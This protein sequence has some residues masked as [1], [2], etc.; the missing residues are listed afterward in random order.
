MDEKYK[1]N[2]LRAGSCAREVRAYG[3]SL[4][5]KGASYNDIIAKIYTKIQEVGA[6]PAFPPQM[7]LNCT[8]AHYLPEPNEDIILSDEIIK[9]DVGVCYEGAIGDCAVTV[10]L[11]GKYEKLI[12]ATE[13]ALLAAEKIIKVG[14]PIRLIGKAIEDTITSFGFEPVRNLSGHGLGVYQIHT[15]PSIPNYHDRSSAVVKPGMT[16]AIEPF[17]TTGKGLIFEA[18][19]PVIFAV[20]KQVCSGIEN[21]LSSSAQVLFRE[22]CTFKGLPFSLHD[23]TKRK[24]PL[25]V[26]KQGIAELLHMNL[27]EGYPPL[28]EEEYGIVAQAENSVLVDMKGKVTITTR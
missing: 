13:A 5:K 20:R 11:S 26:V 24:I 23:F 1:N 8:A 28:I 7:A 18:G 15:S 3:K 21:N 17:A 4:I 10:D 25:Q 27:I 9:L 19:D 12:E 14:V 22:I 16:F 6:S 2:F